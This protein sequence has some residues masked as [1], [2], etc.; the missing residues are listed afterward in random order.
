MTSLR[1]FP[2]DGAQVQESHAKKRIN[3]SQRENVW[4]PFEVFRKKKVLIFAFTHSQCL[5]LLL[6]IIL[7]CNPPFI[8]CEQLD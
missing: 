7:K 4:R 2:P 8:L 1:I 5:Y 6:K 3:A